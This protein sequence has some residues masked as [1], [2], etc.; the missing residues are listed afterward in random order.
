MRLGIR[1]LLQSR[2]NGRGAADCA[3]GAHSALHSAAVVVV[4]TTLLRDEYARQDSGCTKIG[5]RPS[6]V[7]R[8][9]LL[10]DLLEAGSSPLPVRVAH[11]VGK[12]CII[13]IHGIHDARVPFAYAIDSCAD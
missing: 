6:L 1:I 9:L 3:R 10:L 12:V 13:P 7:E 5:P 11:L 8:A 4:K 2:Q